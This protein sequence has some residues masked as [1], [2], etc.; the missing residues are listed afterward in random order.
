M[1]PREATAVNLGEQSA[2]LPPVKDLDKWL[3]VDN[4]VREVLPASAQYP[5]PSENLPF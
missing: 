1:T 5:Q 3:W 4:C 2:P